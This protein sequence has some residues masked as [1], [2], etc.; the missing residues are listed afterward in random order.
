MNETDFIRQQL[1]AERAHLR[2]ILDA[3]PPASAAGAPA[4]PVALYIDWAGRRLLQQF[5]AHCATLQAVPA[6]GLE[7]TRPLHLQAERLLALMPA[8]TQ[9]EASLDALAGGTFRVS[10]WRQAAQLNADTILEERRLYA[11][12]RGAAGLT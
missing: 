12:A 8:L 11:A 6:L 2:Q 3:L 7:T 9:L 1:A 10:H 5:Q 4:R